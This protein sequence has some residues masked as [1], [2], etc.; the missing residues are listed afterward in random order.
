VKR[1]IYKV[2]TFFRFFKKISYK[3][4][5]R[6]KQKL[7]VTGD[8]NVYIMGIPE[9]N[10]VGDHAIAYA[11]K[12]FLSKAYREY[13]II[14]ITE[15]E[16]LFFFRFITKKI[17]EK[18]PIFLQGGGNIDDRYLDQQFIREKII[19]KLKR[20]KIII[21]PQTVNFSDSRFG[22]KEKKR[23]KKML[24]SENVTVIAR[25]GKSYEILHKEMGLDNIKLCPDVVLTLNL[26][27]EFVRQDILL[28]LRKDIETIFCQKN[29]EHIYDICKGYRNINEIDTCLDYD[30]SISNRDREF[31]KMISRIQT[32]E[33]V[34]T[35][36]L[37]AAIF[38]I[39]TST[40]CIILPNNNHKLTEL[41]KWF[42]NDERILLC[43]NLSHLDQCLS[44]MLSFV[45]KE[46]YNNKKIEKMLLECVRE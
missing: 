12:E 19:K 31:M 11:E 21:F 24:Q 22:Q 6:L 40:P 3:D 7:E 32:A 17:T 20:N 16:V 36:R 34:V 29:R 41:K 8:R 1:R 27:K 18:D 44:K 13:N 26:T 15:K 45:K 35:D 23:T 33:L 2:Y 9:Y 14:E 43:D 10:N 37:H 5:K 42:E 39:I 30:V 46:K 25:D 4:K 38:A 28:V